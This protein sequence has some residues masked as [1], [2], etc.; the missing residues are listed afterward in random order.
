MSVFGLSKVC[1]FVPDFKKKP[2]ET[3]LLRVTV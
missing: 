1:I 2:I 3:A